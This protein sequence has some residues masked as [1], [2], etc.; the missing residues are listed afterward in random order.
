M[1]YFTER[2]DRLKGCDDTYYIVVIEDTS[3]KQVIGS[4][5]LVKERKFIRQCASV[6]IYEFKTIFKYTQLKA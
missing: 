6:H 4:G 2:F 3:V 1:M 5:T